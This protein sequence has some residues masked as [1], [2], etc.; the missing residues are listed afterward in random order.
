MIRDNGD[1][2]IFTCKETSHK[3]LYDFIEGADKERHDKKVRKRAVTEIFRYR[4]IENVPLRD[5]KD[6]MTVDWISFQIVDAKGKVKYTMA[7]VTACRSQKTPSP[8]SSPVAAPDGKL[9]MKASM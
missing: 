8:I 4:W 5:A 6:A 7:C 2:F 3:A 1:D 9:R